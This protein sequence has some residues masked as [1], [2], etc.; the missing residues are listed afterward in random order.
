MNDMA[1]PHGSIPTEWKLRTKEVAWEKIRQSPLM[2]GCAAGDVKF[3]VA[4]LGGF[5]DFVDRFPAII[6]GTFTDMPENISPRLKKFLRRAA[7]T[8][9]GTLA[10]MEK[11]ERSHR[12]LWLRSAAMVDLDEKR[13]MEW[14]VL[15]EIDRISIT[16]DKAS[17]ATKLLYFVAVEIVAEGISDFLNSSTAFKEVLGKQGMG[18][19]RVHVVHPADGTT[20]EDIAYKAAVQMLEADGKEPTEKEIN[21]AVQVCVDLFIDAARACNVK[22]AT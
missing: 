5:W 12:A 13:L 16:L 2:Q 18:W 19:F 10:E 3:I 22:F 8:L 21:D 15:P 17:P 9:S 14:V 6:R 11:D 4:L 7:P 1:I 20:H